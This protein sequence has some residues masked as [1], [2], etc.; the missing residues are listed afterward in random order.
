LIIDTDA[1]NTAHLHF[2]KFGIATARRAWVEKK[3]VVN[4]KSLK[5]FLKSLK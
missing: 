4:T 1:H 2:M 3:D 5:E